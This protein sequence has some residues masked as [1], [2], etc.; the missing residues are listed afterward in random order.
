MKPVDSAAEL[1]RL[2]EQSGSDLASALRAL[3][4]RGPDATELASLATRLSLQGVVMTPAPPTAPA[5]ASFGPRWKLALVGTAVVA[6]LGS[7]LFLRAPTAT[8]SL[9]AFP[10]EVGS[11]PAPQLGTGE[12]LAPDN[13]GRAA[14]TPAPL[15][16][17]TAFA[18]SPGPSSARSTSTST[19]EASDA[20]APAPGVTPEPLKVAEPLPRNETLVKGQSSPA[21]RLAANG[22]GT[23]ATDAA[24]PTEL[25]LLRGA[26]L[27]LKGSPAE[28]LR[29]AEQH[30]V[31][32]P[33]GKLTQE[34]ELIAISA[35]VALGRRTAAL[36]RATSFEQA[37]PSSPYRKQIG[38]LLQ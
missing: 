36:S 3:S 21:Q 16:S 10:T 22:A 14:A 11:A 8:R 13:R 37:F 26:R 7:W 4:A 35:L 32:Y 30:R 28:A 2:S 31:S 27:A 34:R 20:A 1:L 12:R 25:E 6:G 17:P 29:L 33:S 9:R 24:L 18:P 19:A 38:E 23:P 5:A 15:G